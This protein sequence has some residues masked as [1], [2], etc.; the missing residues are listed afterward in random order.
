MQEWLYQSAPPGV[1]AKPSAASVG[2][3]APERAAPGVGSQGSPRVT[4]RPP[5]A[6]GGT[7]F[8]LFP[9]RPP[10][11]S[12][13]RAQLLQLSDDPLLRQSCESAGARAFRRNL[14]AVRVG[15]APGR[16]GRAAGAPAPASSW[17]TLGS[18]GSSGTSGPAGEWPPAGH[19]GRRGEPG[20]GEGSVP[21]QRCTG[22]R[23]PGC[24]VR[25]PTPGPGGLW[26]PVPRAGVRWPFHRAAGRPVCLDRADA[27]PR[28][29]ASAPGPLRIPNTVS[30][31]ARQSGSPGRPSRAE[32]PRCWV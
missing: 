14:S 9:W 24:K 4:E 28:S 30:L 17:P 26:C 16:G 21:P 29:R 32:T 13:P 20:P 22:P 12:T 27:A 2:L 8:G 15:P 11:P 3:G 25:D 1:S 5:P 6:A 10:S 19:E 18:S 23:C 7:G 31:A